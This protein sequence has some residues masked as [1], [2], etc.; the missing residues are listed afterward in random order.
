MYG[1]WIISILFLILHKSLNLMK[2]LKAFYM[3]FN[4]FQARHGILI[5]I[6]DEEICLL[7]ESVQPILP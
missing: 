6:A 5:P 1:V 2:F 7:F 3:D 4:N